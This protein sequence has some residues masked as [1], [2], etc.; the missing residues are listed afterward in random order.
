MNYCTVTA[1][2]LGPR[3]R[4]YPVLTRSEEGSHH[5]QEECRLCN[6]VIHPHKSLT[7]DYILRSSAYRNLPY[8]QCYGEGVG[9][10]NGYTRTTVLRTKPGAALWIHEYAGERGERNALS[11]KTLQVAF[12]GALF[13]RLFRRRRLREAPEKPQADY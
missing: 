11:R 4:S 9:E 7:H 1:C 2:F 10:A 12:I 6:P 13:G 3:V 5:Q 8:R